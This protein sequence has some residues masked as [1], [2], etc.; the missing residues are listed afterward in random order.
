[1]PIKLK[2]IDTEFTSLERIRDIHRIVSESFENASH[3]ISSSVVHLYLH[4]KK[5]EPELCSMK[6][7]QIIDINTTGRLSPKGN[8]WSKLY[9]V[10]E[11]LHDVGNIG[12]LMVSCNFEEKSSKQSH[13]HY[14]SVYL[15]VNKGVNHLGYSA[16]GSKIMSDHSYAKVFF[17]RFIEE[18]RVPISMREEE[19]CY[20]LD[21]S[22]SG[23][24]RILRSGV[25]GKNPTS[26]SCEIEDMTA[27]DILDE[28]K[29]FINIFSSGKIFGF[30]WSAHCSPGEE[31]AAVSK[32]IFDSIVTLQ[33]P[34]ESH[35]LDMEITLSEI[36]GL[37]TIKSLCGKKDRLFC[38][39]CSFD[40][41]GD[42]YANIKI[43][44]SHKGHAIS[45][46]MRTEDNL[47][48][49]EDKIGIKF[50]YA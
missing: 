44:T 32:Q 38:E 15:R 9:Q 35:E 4:P 50:K 12:Q 40:L 22:K 13:R 48:L 33:V 18:T 41:P 11:L 42:N 1:M 36:S 45:L 10:V 8:P 6:G 23:H 46:E 31:S 20:Y 2:P 47:E 34:A 39:I 19:E 37:E 14:D 27:K 21:H 30:R 25:R 3:P 49:I 43:E 24:L 16:N 26:F 29:D 5:L 28:M 7:V 17:N